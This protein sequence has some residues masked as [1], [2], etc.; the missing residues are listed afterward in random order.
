[1]VDNRCI[2]TDMENKK[3]IVKWSTITHYE[4]EVDARDHIEAELKFWDGKVTPFIEVQ[5]GK[6]GDLDVR[7]ANVS[8]E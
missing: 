4:A 7:E 2:M 5:G 6:L 1:M 3:F 8:P